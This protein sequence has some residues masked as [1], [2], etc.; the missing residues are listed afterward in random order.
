MGTSAAVN[1]GVQNRVGNVNP[2]QARQIK[3]YNCNAQENRVVLDEEQMLFI[4]GGQD[5]VVDEDMDEPTIRDLALNDVV[6]EHYEVHDMLDDVQPNCLVN[7]DAEYTGE[8]NMIPYDQNQATI[9]DGKVVVQ[10]IQGRQNRGQARQIKCYN[11]NA[12]ENR[13][14]LDEEQMLFIIGGQDNVV[15]EDMDEPTIRDLAL[16]VDNVF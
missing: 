7:S 2:G 10:N 14:V 13:V 6:C 3:C 11:C 12:Q 15:D 8:T 16:N 4:I 1:G 5:N 9:Q